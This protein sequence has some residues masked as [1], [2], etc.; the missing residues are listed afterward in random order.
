MLGRQITISAQDIRAPVV[1][2]MVV[3][4]QA[5]LRKRKFLKFK[6]FLVKFHI[7]IILSNAGSSSYNFMPGYFNSNPGGGNYGGSQALSGAQS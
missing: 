5:Q 2:V 4:N 6:Q 1:V 3:L 7:N